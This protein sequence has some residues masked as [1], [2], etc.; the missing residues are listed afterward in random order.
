L[1][2]IFYTVLEATRPTCFCTGRRAAIHLDN[3]WEH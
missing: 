1:I 2:I 3:C